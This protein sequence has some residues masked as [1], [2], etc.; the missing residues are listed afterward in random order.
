M[1]PI[2]LLTLTS[3]NYLVIFTVLTLFFFAI[4]FFIIQ[5]EVFHSTDE[6]L[7]NRKMR[8]LEEIRE[9]GNAIPQ[10]AFQFTD[11]IFTPFDGKPANLDVYADTIIYEKVDNE[12]DEFRKLTTTT[13][14]GDKSYKL[15][16]FLPRLETHEIVSSIIKSLTLV[17]ILM[18]TAFFFTSRFFSK[19]LW[20]PFYS[21]LQQLNKF[22][23]DRSQELE[24]K[25]ERIEEF[26]KLNESITNLIARTRKTFDNQK[27]F[28][29]NASHEMQTPLAITQSK[30]EQ[31]ID[32]PNLTEE[33]SEILQTLINSTQRI[34]RLNRT[35]L[36][37]SKIENEQ[38][39][40]KERVYLAPLVEE[41][42][43]VFDD[44]RENLGINIQVNI[45]RNISVLGNKVLVDL[46]L[47]NLIKNSFSHNIS[48]GSITIHANHEQFRISNTSSSAAIPPEKLFQRFY[49]NT[50]RKDS[51]GLGLAIVNKICTINQWKIT[52]S[53][54][55]NRH[56][57][58][59]SFN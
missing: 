51:W 57:F 28:I 50:P 8:I 12:W 5:K 25:P 53:M 35:L 7:Y 36:L 38:F 11:F 56:S 48:N 44:Q 42:L 49:K 18:V 19:K 34:I 15:E 26:D 59:V 14:I 9:N 30:L 47:T 52:Y 37:L 39:L 45:D 10:V 54:E 24:L 33:Q 58:L 13:G 4:F 16:I 46:L 40:E 3:R 43:S 22:E 2:K 31:L 55:G 29:E 32:D 6:I 20:Q 27:Q 21:T 23:I 41:I 17:F 1:K